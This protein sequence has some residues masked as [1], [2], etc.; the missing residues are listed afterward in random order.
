M[1]EEHEVFHRSA[2]KPSVVHAASAPSYQQ[3]HQPARNLPPAH[4]PT[5]RPD[6]SLWGSGPTI[7][8]TLPSEPHPIRAPPSQPKKFMSLEE[9]EAEILAMNSQK[10]PAAVAP[11][12]LFQ[13]APLPQMQQ[14]IHQQPEM[15]VY[16]QQ[17]HQ[18]QYQQ[19]QQQQRG[20][21][22]H[23]HNIA[24]VGQPQQSSQLMHQHAEQQLRG[25]PPVQA[26]LTH[27]TP[28]SETRNAYGMAPHAPASQLQNMN[29]IERARFLEDESKRLK[30]N[31]KIAQLVRF[32]PHLCL[33]RTHTNTLDTRHAT[34]AS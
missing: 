29:E 33:S 6:M 12:P 20:F 16:Q 15:G 18:Q 5:L 25:P 7:T 28:A 23:T 24:R 14:Y 4:V 1:D 2:R 30:R 17:Q 31:H 10:P 11:Q 26:R 21:Q 22:M 32:P 3:Q 27:E 9:V 19:Q 13:A 34:M 8:S